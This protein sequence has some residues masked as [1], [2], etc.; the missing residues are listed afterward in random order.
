MDLSPYETLETLIRSSPRAC[1]EQVTHELQTARGV[2]ALYLRVL[3]GKALFKLSQF[4]EATEELETTLQSPLVEEHASVRSEAE[5]ALANICIQTTATD[6]GIDHAHRAIEFARIGNDR[7]RIGLGQETLACLLARKGDDQDAIRYHLS[8]IEI[9]RDVAPIELVGALNNLSY[10]Y[11]RQGD[12][13]RTKELVQEAIALCPQDDHVLLSTLWLNLSRAHIQLGAFDEAERDCLESL[14]HSGTYGNQRQ[15]AYATVVFVSIQV[16][17][18]NTSFEEFR[19]NLQE[20]LQFFT[21]ID[22]LRGMFLTEVQMARVKAKEGFIDEGLAIL[23]NACV[24]HER[25][26]PLWLANVHAVI[27]EISGWANDWSAAYA[28]LKQVHTHQNVMRAGSPLP[29]DVVTT[30][31][32]DRA[33]PLSRPVATSHINQKLR[34]LTQVKD[35]AA[36]FREEIQNLLRQSVTAETAIRQIR[37]KLKTL[38]ERIDY[39]IFETDFLTVNPLFIDNLKSAYPKLSAIQLRICCL[40]RIELSASEASRLLAISQ[41]TLENHRYR[42]RKLFGLKSERLTDFLVDF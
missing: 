36:R 27:E 16:S 19:K 11:S 33:A 22:D 37:E 29:T 6:K 12:Y 41:R 42:L 38:P 40:T 34:E 9:L 26:K 20:Q 3:L 14:S 15:S 5:R 39:E 31:H 2:G 13:S 23:K 35:I 18:G 25:D 4:E 32:R 1:L 7:L 17:K 30:L 8:A 10:H 28:A 24:E 21:D